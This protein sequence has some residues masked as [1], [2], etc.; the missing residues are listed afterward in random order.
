MV[1]NGI[2][3]RTEAMG[4]IWPKIP[5][6]AMRYATLGVEF[7]AIF[8]VFLFAGLWLDARLN[9]LPAFTLVGMVVGFAGGMYRFIRVARQYRQEQVDRS[10]HDDQPKAE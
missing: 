6:E 5:P 7:C 10:G 8:M 1:G 4:A 2:N 3:W 9:S